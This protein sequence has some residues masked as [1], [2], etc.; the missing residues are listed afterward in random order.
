MNFE[1]LKVI[2]DSQADAPMYAVNEEGLHAL[3]RQTT[4]HFSRRMRWQ[5]LQTYLAS[6]LVVGPISFLLVGHFSGLNPFAATWDVLALFMAAGAWLYFG[7]RV[8]VGRKRQEDRERHFTASL[9]DEIDRDIAQVTYQLDGRKQ[10]MLSFVPPHVGSLLLVWVVFRLSN[11]AWW[12]I[13]PVLVVLLVNLVFESRSQQR[14]VDR[15]LIP[16]KRELESLR[17]NLA[18]AQSSGEDRD[19][20]VKNRDINAANMTADQTADAQRRARE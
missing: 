8:F 1:D 3:L 11:Y 15:E 2:W 12:A 5:R 17:D 19:R 13:V 16:R 9:R 7:G 18:A 4:A 14:L 10:I 20:W 6:F